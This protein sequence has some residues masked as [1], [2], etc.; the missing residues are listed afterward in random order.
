MGIGDWLR[1][2]RATAAAERTSAETDAQANK[3][4]V[5][6]AR[7]TTRRPF[8]RVS[9]CATGGEELLP[10]AS[11][12]GGIPYVPADGTVP[13]GMFCIAQ[14]NLAEVPPIDAL[15]RTGIVQFWITD[16]DLHGM[17]FDHG[18][19]GDNGQRTI[20]HASTDAPHAKGIAPA[21]ARGPLCFD[22]PHGRRLRFELATE[23]IPVGDYQW[24]PFCERH[25]IAVET[26]LGDDDSWMDSHGHKIGGYCAFTQEDPRSPR[27]PMWSLLQLDSD[28]H[29]F[30]GDT[31]IA[32]WFIREADLRAATFA[33]VRYYWDCC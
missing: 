25:D 17:T 16:D 5:A 22:D 4:R 33:N 12:L 23:I 20:Y 31:G 14:L 13:D 2:R 9:V 15:P 28:E 6:A 7:E 8:V 10:T 19:R 1:K 21:G 3:V 11:K 18:V 24:E 26:E 30:W 32:H 27:D 29:V